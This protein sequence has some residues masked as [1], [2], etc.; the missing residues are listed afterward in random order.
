VRVDKKRYPIIVIAVALI[1]TL[2]LPFINYK[3][4]PWRVLHKDYTHVY[5]GIGA[6]FSYLK[7][8]YILENPK[9]YDT[10]LFGSSRNFAISAA[11]VS[12]KSYNMGY[13]F[14]VVGIHL[15]NLKSIVKS[16]KLKSVWI[17]LNDFEIW[18]DPNIF[19]TDPQRRPYP[20][21]FYEQ[22]LLYKFYL[23]MNI[24]GEQTDILAKKR[25]LEYSTRMV[26]KG[27]DAQYHHHKVQPY[28]VNHAK[29]LNSMAA[30]TLLYNDDSYRIDQ[31]IEEI[32]EIKKL[33]NK[34]N[35]ELKLFFYPV[36]YKTYMAYNQYKIEEF[37]R[38][39]ASFTGFYD[40]YELNSYAFNEMYWSNTG[41]FNDSLADLII[42]DIK[43]EKN[44][45]NSK[46]IEEHIA[47]GRL[48]IVD[49]LKKRFPIKDFIQKY[50]QN[51]DLSTLDK[52]VDIY[53]KNKNYTLNKD[54]KLVKKEDLIILTSGNDP[55]M[56]IDKMS[57]KSPNALI[58]VNLESP[59]K[60]IFQIYY[61]KK[62]T[63]KYSE[64]QA[65]RVFLRKGENRF[66]LLT[67]SGY[68]RYGLRIDPV[69]S[70]GI[71]KIKTLSIY[72][73]K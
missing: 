72:G 29:R 49:L 11:Q 7:V 25:L 6:N 66:N 63:D 62:L 59:K 69:S 33:C 13:T 46:N 19:Y 30:F 56:E 65:Y 34:H 52:L 70:S 10:L 18:K 44:Y 1:V 36:F 41:H 37:K 42:N 40:F 38:K 51:I 17:G 64:K 23:F 2:L 14:G 45:V 71:Y 32:K 67:P 21:N 35:I 60:T 61:K 43:A 68:L 9:K 48:L 50:N 53:Q 26:K 15:Q 27:E 4:D 12:D 55:H 28:N 31:T 54:M 39:L 16:V 73:I 5:N 57:L 58:S 24:G 22:I 20:L 3:T 47:K 8:A